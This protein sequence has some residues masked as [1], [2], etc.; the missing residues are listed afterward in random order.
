MM[1]ADNQ[2]GFIDSG[3]LHQLS[4]NHTARTKAF[5]IDCDAFRKSFSALPYT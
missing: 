2:P 4:S 5:H 1:E 3:G